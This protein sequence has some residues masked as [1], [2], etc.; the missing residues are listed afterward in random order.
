MH[1]VLASCLQINDLGRLYWAL[2]VSKM[3]TASKIT[4]ISLNVYGPARC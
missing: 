3:F 2:C 1:F 4:M